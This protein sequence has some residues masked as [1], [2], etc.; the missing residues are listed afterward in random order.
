MKNIIHFRADYDTILHIDGKLAGVCGKDDSLDIIPQKDKMYVTFSTPN[1]LSQAM[2]LYNMCDVPCCDNEYLE[3]IPYMNRH[4]DFCYHPICYRDH[5]LERVL[6]SILLGKLFINVIGKNKDCVSTLSIFEN[7]H[8]K[9]SYD[10]KPF[11]DIE[12]TQFGKVIVLICK[13]DSK[14]QFVLIDTKDYTITQNYQCDHISVDK[15]T[16][17]TLQYLDDLVGQGIVCN[18][19]TTKNMECT[20]YPVYRDKKAYD[21]SDRRLLPYALLMC[22]KSN[23]IKHAKSFL[24][25]NISACSDDNLKDYFGDIKGIYPDPYSQSENHYYYTIKCDKYKKYDFIIEG[26]K[27]VDINEID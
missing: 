20:S 4:Y 24:A 11:D 22:I 10:I 12:C 21:I 8:L 7:N 16:I 17:H 5:C 13:K 9:M 1:M 6:Y 23:N 27:I 3:C 14:Y 18:Y 26:D 25:S 19:D 2:C 15:N